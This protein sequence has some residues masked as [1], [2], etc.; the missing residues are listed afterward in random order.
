MPSNSDAL[1][2][3]HCCATSL[4]ILNTATYDNPTLLGRALLRPPLRTLSKLQVAFW[5]E[6]DDLFMK[7]LSSS[8]AV[9][10]QH[11]GGGGGGGGGAKHGREPDSLQQLLQKDYGGPLVAG[12]ELSFGSKDKAVRGYFPF[13]VARLDAP[14]RARVLLMPLLG[15][16]AHDEEGGGGGGGAAA[17]SARAAAIAAT[18]AAAAASAASATDFAEALLAAVPLAARAGARFAVLLDAGSRGAAAAA[19]ARLG[20]A[21]LAHAAAATAPEALARLP[22]P[23]ACEGAPPLAPLVAALLPPRAKG[24]GGGCWHTDERVARAAGALAGAGGTLTLVLPTNEDLLLHGGAAHAF[25]RDA[26]AFAGARFPKLS[27]AVKDAGGRTVRAPGDVVAAH[28]EGH[29]PQVG[30]VPVAHA[31]AAVAPAQPG[32]RRALYDAVL[33][34]FFSAAAAEEGRA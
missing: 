19:D 1:V 13:R 31:I 29:Y 10:V 18:T 22:V 24:E 8:V 5:C 20:K 7:V 27:A 34:A 6:G 2:T 3:G 9:R 33:S 30:G 16:A 15:L 17:P 28:V 11:P 14:P 4:L 23:W 12:S 26:F 25:T 32:G 21:C